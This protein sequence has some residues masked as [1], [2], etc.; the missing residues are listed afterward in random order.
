M[1]GMVVVRGCALA[2]VAFDFLAMM[3][4]CVIVLLYVS[5]LISFVSMW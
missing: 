3:M 4:A 1:N 2:V 5:F